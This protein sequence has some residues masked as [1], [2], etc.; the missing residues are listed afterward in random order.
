M[1][2]V[3]QYIKEKALNIQLSLKVRKYFE[4]FLALE[5]KQKQILLD[6]QIMK[7]LTESLRCEVLADI[8]KKVVLSSQFLKS[9]FND[10]ILNTVCQKIE[11]L[12]FAPGDDV[13][14][15]NSQA[16]RLIFI[17]DG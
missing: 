15:V 10:S 1:K 4:H 7:C 2:E 9:T 8:Y 14:T 6:E 5:S 17:I 13:V 16:D 3:N 11:Q 12:N